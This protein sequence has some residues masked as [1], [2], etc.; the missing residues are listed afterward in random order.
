MLKLTTMRDFEEWVPK[1]WIVQHRVQEQRYLFDN[2]SEI[3]FRPFR[4]WRELKGLTVGAA[5]VD[6]WTEVPEESTQVLRSR[7]RQPGMPGFLGGVTNTGGRMHY[8]YKQFVETAARRS[9]GRRYIQSSSLENL[10]TPDHYHESLLATN[11]GRDRDKHVFGHW[12]D[13]DTM[14]WRNFDRKSCIGPRPQLDHSWDIQLG[15][16]VGFEH[17]FAVVWIAR[18]EFRVGDH[19]IN[20]GIV[21]REYW[22]QHESLEKICADIQHH[23]AED[24]LT[25]APAP[26]RIW[27]DPNG[28]RER[29]EM[30]RM[31]DPKLQLQTQG[32]VNDV[33][34]GIRSV[35]SAFLPQ[36]DGWPRLMI[37]SEPSPRSTK[38]HPLLVDQVESYQHPENFLRENE[39]LTH[40]SKGRSI[41][42]G[43]DALRYGWFSGDKRFFDRQIGFDPA[44]HELQRRRQWVQ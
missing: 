15:I 30:R 22:S 43:C 37:C 6:E 14:I 39:I 13:P 36:K 40:D 34:P 32:A 5:L 26:S 23:I 35:N 21:Y 24:R 33:I 38:G 18:K 12:V 25:G 17:W 31:T 9:F 10:S 41:N 8:L 19:A 44:M 1:E 11:V 29:F 4:D 28:V 42:D 27:V 3:F 20:R 7:L 16:D 2:G